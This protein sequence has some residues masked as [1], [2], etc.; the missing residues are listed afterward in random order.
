MRMIRIAV[1]AAGVCLLLA[2]SAFART[3]VQINY[4]D[5]AY[6]TGAWPSGGQNVSLFLG[7]KFGTGG[8]Q[9]VVKNDCAPTKRDGTPLPVPAV[10]YWF[11]NPHSI[12]AKN[13]S[14]EP[15]LGDRSVR[16]RDYNYF[17]RRAIMLGCRLMRR[18]GLRRRNPPI[19]PYSCA[20]RYWK[21]YRGDQGRNV[22]IRPCR[23]SKSP[24]RLHTAV[25]ASNG[26]TYRKWCDGLQKPPF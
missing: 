22:L 8:G 6:M 17:S 4:R 14:K 24:Y 21:S 9:R 5:G 25:F 1:T 13:C 7:D 23:G 19:R 26:V 18:E 2:S 11:F 20:Y 10:G 16:P 12:V 15:L 3:N